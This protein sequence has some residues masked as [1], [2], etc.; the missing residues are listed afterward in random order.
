[1]KKLTSA[2]VRTL[3]A[4]VKIETYVGRDS[5]VCYV[6]DSYHGHRVY[7]T[8]SDE[9][10][11]VR[12]RPATIEALCKGGMLRVTASAYRKMEYA[13]TDAGREA[14]QA[15]TTSRTRKPCHGCGERHERNADELC[16]DCAGALAAAH[17]IVAR[18]NEAVSA[19]GLKRTS[20]LGFAPADQR[21][22]YGHGGDQVTS[23]VSAATKRLARTICS[24]FNRLLAAYPPAPPSVRWDGDL[25]LGGRLVPEEALVAA[26]VMAAAMSRMAHEAYV[27]GVNH[28]RDVL[29]QMAAGEIAVGNE[30][31]QLPTWEPPYGGWDA[32]RSAIDAQYQAGEISADGPAWAPLLELQEEMAHPESVGAPQADNPRSA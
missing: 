4:L 7:L 1:M 27:A 22:T 12:P 24:G 23:Y 15:R 30:G 31:Q 13:L 16:G 3:E 25:E 20:L 17:V 21:Q 29:A 26:R 8:E 28:G 32:E 2:Q 19:G 10:M 18:A 6:V 11:R 14:A 5:V 9:R